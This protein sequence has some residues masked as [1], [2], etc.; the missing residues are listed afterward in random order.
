MSPC[1][2]I[3]ALLPLFVG[4]DLEA[5]QDARVRQHLGS[6]GAGSGRGCS[7]C[8]SALEGLESTRRALL[9][10]PELS[11][12]PHLDLWPA[13]RAQ[14][15]FE[16][17]LAVP[18]SQRPSRPV[19]AAAA[20]GGERRRVVVLRI[21]AAVLVAAGALLLALRQAA[22]GPLMESPDPIAIYAPGLE[23][24]PLPV[25]PVSTGG[26]RRLE[27]GELPLSDEAHLFWEGR[28]SWSP[29]GLPVR[30]FRAPQKLAPALV[31]DRSLR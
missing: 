23:V 5:P 21:A 7:A 1:N 15:L 18:R 4:G 6:R 19:A 17:L 31:G 26:L 29:T 14:M 3:Q 22:K 25:S 28:P 12:A 24:A 10:L 30:R 2:D 20:N 11:P 27:A 8:L 16:G 9:A 13:I